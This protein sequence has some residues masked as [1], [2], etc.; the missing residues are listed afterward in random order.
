MIPEHPPKG[1]SSSNGAVEQSG[2]LVREL[3]RVFRDQ[4]EHNAQMTL[5]PQ[6]NV[7]QWMIRWAAINISRY[8]AG[9]D[10]KSA[11]ERR[12]GRPCRIPVVPFAEKVWY[13]RLK[14]PKH[15]L[16]KSNSPWEEGI[17]L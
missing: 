4:V 7:V 17:W 11:Y 2:Q 12:R 6:D 8:H 9:K 13:K 14:H 10:G 15:D 16:G 5:S 1:E 3:A